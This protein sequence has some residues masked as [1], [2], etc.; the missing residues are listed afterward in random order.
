MASLT[1]YLLG[2]RLEPRSLVRKNWPCADNWGGHKADVFKW[3]EGG[4][5]AAIGIFSLWNLIATK[6]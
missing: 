2:L 6:I 1:K 4:A 3:I 5:E